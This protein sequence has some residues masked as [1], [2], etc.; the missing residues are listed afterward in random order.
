MSGFGFRNLSGCGNLNGGITPT[1]P[2]GPFGAQRVRQN[3]RRLTLV[4][5]QGSNRRYGSNAWGVYT[6][7][8]ETEYKPQAFN[9]YP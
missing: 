1:S 3:K 9:P 7:F 6:F 4:D 5:P 8:I 2:Y